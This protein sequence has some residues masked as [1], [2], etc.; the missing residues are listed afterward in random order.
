[1]NSDA[2]WWA[3]A[4][5]RFFGPALFFSADHETRGERARR[6][7]R[8]KSICRGCPVVEQCLTSALVRRE[9]FGVWGGTSARE[10]LAEVTRPDRT[11]NQY[12]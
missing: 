3:S 5:C 8:A 11:E 6:E 1:M 12:R 9:R 2:E 7:E 4:A 10:R